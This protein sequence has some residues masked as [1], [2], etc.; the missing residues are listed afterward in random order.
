MVH[1]TNVASFR[2]LLS[3]SDA[4]A[5]YPHN[6]FLPLPYPVLSVSDVQ[7]FSLPA[8]TSILT[9]SR[10]S[11][12]KPQVVAAFKMLSSGGHFPSHPEAQDNLTVSNVSASRIL[13]ADWSAT[14][15]GRTVCGYRY[16]LTPTGVVFAN[17]IYIAGRLDDGTVVLDVTL[18][19][20]K[21]KLL[22]DAVTALIDE[23]ADAKRKGQTS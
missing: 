17:A 3:T 6:A 12:S 9:T 23:A 7:S 4:I 20:L 2:S 19:T 15:V 13:E 8:L 18:N 16:Q 21:L 14:G 11:L 22:V 10:L 5:T 1:I